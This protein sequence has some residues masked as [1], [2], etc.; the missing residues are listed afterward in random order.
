MLTPIISLLTQ[1]QGQ[2]LT[3]VPVVAGLCAATYGVVMMIGDHAKG[4][5]GLIWTG[6]GGAVALGSTTIAASIHP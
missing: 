1:L 5:Q 6:I 3:L 4:R 2:V